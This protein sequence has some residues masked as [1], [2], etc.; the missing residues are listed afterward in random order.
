MNSEIVIAMYRPYDSSNDAAMKELIR[1]HNTTLRVE[2][3]ITDR[4]SVLMQSQDGTFIEVF[5]W[6]PGAAKAAHEHPAIQKIWKRM[7]EIGEFAPLISLP[8]AEGKFPHFKPVDGVV[9]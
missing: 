7:E 9:T 1:Q 6:L 2:E 5:E 4:P 8:E 3:L